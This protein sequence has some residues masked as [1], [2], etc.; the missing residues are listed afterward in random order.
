MKIL[1][2]A[3]NWLGDAVMSIPALR[4]IRRTRPDAHIAIL[5][6]PWVADLYQGQGLADEIIP[7]ENAGRHRGIA[8]AERLAAELR[9]QKFDVALLLQNAFLAAWIAARAG[10]PERIG[11]AREA[12][13]WM[14][15]RPIAVPGAGE[16]PAHETYYYLELLRRAGWLDQMPSVE[17]VRLKLSEPACDA[18]EANLRQQLVR[19]ESFRVALAPGA[20]FGTAKCWPAERYA[21]LAD[22]LIAEFD[23]DVILFGSPTE[24]AVAERVAAKMQR[25]P[26]VLAG[27]T[28]VGDLPALLAACHL[29]IGNDSGAMHV[30]AAVGLPVV[31]VFGPTDPHG[32][33]PRAPRMT[34]V[35]EP[36]SCSPCFLRHCPVDHRCMTR[37][38]VEAVYTAAQHWIENPGIEKRSTTFA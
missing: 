7:F 34:L 36:V 10:I 5:A 22:R 23:A 27:Q 8:G 32:T 28:S 37:V 19:P 24:R 20:A 14:L 35:R 6:R 16:I 38:D 3:T 30:A 21:T 26:I 18:A 11:Y 17:P 9:A 1:V 13:S 33:S 29:F 12:R 31:A 15:T 2:R 25:R 4:A